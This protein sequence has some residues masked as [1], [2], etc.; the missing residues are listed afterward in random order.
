MTPL[1]SDTGS[2][3]LDRIIGPGLLCVF[4]FDG[5]LSPIV[6]EP[7][8]AVLPDAVQQRLLALSKS[9]PVAIITGRSI[10]DLRAR[11]NFKPDY[12]IGNH[13]MEGIP[14]WERRADGYAA[15]CRGWAASLARALNDPP[16][17]DP[18]IRLEDKRYSLSIHYRRAQDQA[19]TERYLAALIGTL[20]PEPRIITGKCVFNLVPQGAPDK[21]SAL[22]H[23]LQDTGALGAIYVGDDVTDE[24][25]F[26][27]ARPDLVSVRVGF[28]EHS[29][30]EFFIDDYGDIEPLL[31]DLLARL[32]RANGGTRQQASA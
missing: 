3:R 14:G 10:D 12:V 25:V 31:D 26:R 18:G 4:D 5:T 19:H 16:R 30:A 29:A 1:S 32:Q 17:A 22:E 9:A 24:D 23:L 13:G 20:H 28:S 27:L 7:E 2:Q 21:G 6:A 15:I 11:L 8:R